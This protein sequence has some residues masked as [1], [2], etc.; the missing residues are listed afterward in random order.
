MTRKTIGSLNLV[1]WGAL[2]LPLFVVLPVL[3]DLVNPVAGNF[4]D[5]YQNADGGHAP[6]NPAGVAILPG[7]FGWVLPTYPDKVVVGNASLGIVSNARLYSL[8]RSVFMQNQSG[9]DAAYAQYISNNAFWYPCVSDHV[10]T[11]EYHAM[12]P[13]VSSSQGASGTE[14]DEVIKFF[15]T[16][17]AFQPATKDVL[18]S[19][20]LLIPTIQMLQ[21]RTRVATD[22]EYL[23]GVAHPSAF[24]DA[25]NSLS[26]QWVANAM[27]PG[28]VP[29]HGAAFH[30]E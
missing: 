6:V 23:S 11:D 7:L 16:L 10:E 30:G 26:M 22:A 24:D 14:I 3:A 19:K 5:Y 21:R 20:G 15:A 4:G 8:V 2:L 28:R 25:D 17:A 13:A 18:R 9:A 1:A 27:L 12:T 29:P